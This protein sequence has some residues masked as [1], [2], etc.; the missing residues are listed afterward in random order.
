SEAYSWGLP[1]ELGHL[2][3]EFLTAQTEPL[4]RLLRA[5]RLPLA[6]ELVSDLARMLSDQRL[7]QD[8]TGETWKATVVLDRAELERQAAIIDGFLARKDYRLA[9]GLMREWL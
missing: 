9:F 8:V 4:R 1:I 2:A 3:G 7:R 6:D 5:Q